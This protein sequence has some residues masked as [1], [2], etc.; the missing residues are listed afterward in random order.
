M[1]MRVRVRVQGAQ[2]VARRLRG[3]KQELAEGIDADVEWTTL[4]AINEARTNSPY[5]T[6][7]LRRGIQLITQDTKPMTRSWGGFRIYTRRQEYEHKTKKG[8][9]RRAQWNA[10]TNLRQRIE[11]TLRRLGGL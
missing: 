8:F 3:K 7:E 4:K 1:G 2:D 6:G 9:M 10:R 11:N 5:K